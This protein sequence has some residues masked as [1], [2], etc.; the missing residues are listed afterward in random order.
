MFDPILDKL[1][2]SAIM[3]A[4][5]RKVRPHSD[6][7]EVVKEAAIS[8]FANPDNWIRGRGIALIHRSATGHLTLL[9]AFVEYTHKRIHGVRELKRESG[10]LEI[11]AEE[12]VTG[13]WWF[14]PQSLRSSSPS[15]SFETISFTTNLHLDE[16]ELYAMDVPVTVHTKN[17]FTAKV[18]LTEATQFVSHEGKRFLFLPSG[19]DVLSCL[20]HEAK[21][22]I[23]RKLGYV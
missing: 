14:K 21:M 2:D 5:R 18:V 15:E 22:E 11:D 1:L 4:S 7:R 9:G 8:T 17:T 16:I 19:L 20:S 13:D 6:R 23:R 12:Y 3:E 10:L